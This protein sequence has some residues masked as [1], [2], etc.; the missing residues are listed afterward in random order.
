MIGF[1][2]IDGHDTLSAAGDLIQ[3]AAGLFGALH[4]AE[5]SASPA[6]AVAPITTAGIGAAINDRLTRAAAPRD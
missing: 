5:E 1:G 6:I 4:R 3:A 2:A